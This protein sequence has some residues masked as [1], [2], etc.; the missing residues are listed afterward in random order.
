MVRCLMPNS[1]QAV[2][3][4]RRFSTPARWPARRGRLRDS[5]QRPL[6]SMMMATCVGTLGSAGATV[7]AAIGVGVHRLD[8]ENFGFFALADLIYLFD[9]TVGELL[10]VGLAPRQVV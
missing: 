1:T 6:P 3:M 4:R 7:S 5:A 8:F 9:V 2:M 10:Q